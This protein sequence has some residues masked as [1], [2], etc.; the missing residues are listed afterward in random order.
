MSI[1]TRLLL[2]VLL[3]TLTTAFIIAGRIFS[4]R[5][6]DVAAATQ[7]VPTEAGDVANILVERIQGTEQLHYGLSH[8]QDLATGDRAACSAYLSQ[9]RNKYP[10]YTGILTINPDGRLFCDSLR[11]GR[12]LDLSDRDYFKKA[13]ASNSIVLQSAFGRLTGVAV[14]QIA[15]PVRDESGALEF[16][17]LA[18]LNLAQLA[19]GTMKQMLDPGWK[20]MLVDLDGVV[21]ASSDPAPGLARAGSSIA[22]S[23]LFRFATAPA[24]GAVDIADADGEVHTW[25]VAHSPL[26]RNAGVLVLVGS[27]K[28]MLLA[29][30]NRR[31]AS[32]LVIQGG[33][34][35]V[36]LLALWAFAELG[37]RR[38]LVTIASMVEKIG[39]NEPHARIPEP[40][41][42]GELGALMGLLNRSAALHEQQRE[43]IEDLD[44]KLRESQKLE[45]MGQLTG[46]VAHDFNNL[47][48]VILGNAEVLQEVLSDNKQLAASAAMVV[49]A[50]ERGA[51]LTQRLLAFARKQ[52]LAPTAVDVNRLVA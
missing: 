22:G 49:H 3:A 30:P 2:I 23:E 6:S 34:S 15:Y 41:P 16:V 33:T 14:L 35:A 20:A 18:S 42:G 40:H 7:R 24:A 37:I 31:L 36:L 39:R 47:L 5:A 1:R 13:K 32:A 46:G 12:E 10:Q 9:V 11:T 50:A 29:T 48:T 25:A 17:L 4:D 52:A 44:S 28:K 45:A 38:H 27:S 21:L 8:A 43:A 51:E 26:L 19:Q